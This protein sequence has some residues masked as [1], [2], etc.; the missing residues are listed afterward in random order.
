MPEG[1]LAQHGNRQVSAAASGVEQAPFAL[2]R[3]LSDGAGN[4][5]IDG[6][7]QLLGDGVVFYG[8]VGHV[9]SFRFGRC[10]AYKGTQTVVSAPLR[11][12]TSITSSGVR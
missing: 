5:G 3:A 8:V 1:A 12:L 2:V 9:D 7:E 10:A 4:H 6:R 11:K